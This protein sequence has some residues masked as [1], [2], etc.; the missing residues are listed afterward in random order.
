MNAKQSVSMSTR[1]IGIISSCPETSTSSSRSWHHSQENV[2]SNFVARVPPN[3]PR[4]RLPGALLSRSFKPELARRTSHGLLDHSPHA[5]EILD[6]RGWAEASES[7][8]MPVHELGI[9]AQGCLRVRCHR[10][11]LVA[12]QPVK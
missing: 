5:F 6:L 3:H 11:P 9:P 12:L 4:R 1:A 10:V 8:K 7:L 2:S